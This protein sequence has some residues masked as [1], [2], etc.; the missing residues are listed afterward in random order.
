MKKYESTGNDIT[1][2]DIIKIWHLKI[3][4]KINIGY[5]EL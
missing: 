3:F 1:D 4:K 5:H 2:E